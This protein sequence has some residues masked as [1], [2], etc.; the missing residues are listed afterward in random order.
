[1][2]SCPGP[3]GAGIPW[4]DRHKLSVV[5]AAADAV[6][7]ADSLSDI[8]QRDGVNTV[9][10][11]AFVAAMF[12]AV[13]ATLPSNYNLAHAVAGVLGLAPTFSKWLDIK[14]RKL[15]KCSTVYN[16]ANVMCSACPSRRAAIVRAVASLLCEFFTAPCPEFGRVKTFLLSWQRR[17]PGR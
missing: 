11:N 15:N 3:L 8:L 7:A 17:R 5:N 10:K 14:L 16:V 13:P 12:T 6:M 1:M 4:A 2:G 9:S